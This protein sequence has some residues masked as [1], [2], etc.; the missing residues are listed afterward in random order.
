MKNKFIIIISLVI[1]VIIAGGSAAFYFMTSSANRTEYDIPFTYDDGFV[2]KIKV[3]Q[4]TKHISTFGLTVMQFETE[5]SED[6]VKE[7]YD[8]YFSTL[9]VVYSKGTASNDVVYYYDKEQRVVLRDFKVWRLDNKTKFNIGLE[10]CEDI[11]SD[12]EWS[13]TEPK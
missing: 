1:V 4:G 6:E 5:L 10:K 2:A 12:S 7:Y 13:A 9:Q 3:P 11:N 8:N